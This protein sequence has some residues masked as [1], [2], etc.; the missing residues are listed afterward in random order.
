M[1]LSEKDRLVVDISRLANNWRQWG[2]GIGG[3]NVSTSTECDDCVAVFSSDDYSVHLRMDGSWWV[4]DT[5]N[6]RGQ[7]RNAVA[8]LSSF[9]LAEKYLIWSWATTASSTLASGALG[10]DLARLGYAPGVE[11]SQVDRVHQ[12]CAGDDCAILSVVDATIFSHL[13]TK[14]VD[15]IEQLARIGR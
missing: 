11:V 8:K 7:R 13:M 2:P 14:S 1:G 4:V 10:A 6:D 5:I 15:E 12:I 9:D 3:G